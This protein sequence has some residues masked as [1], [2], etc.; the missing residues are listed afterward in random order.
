MGGIDADRM[1]TAIEQTKSVY[2]FV[3]APD[4]ALYFTSD[5]Q[6]SD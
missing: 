5:L 4:A 3:N 6:P 1:A 2:E